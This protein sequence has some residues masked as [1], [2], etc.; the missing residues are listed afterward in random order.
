[1]NIVNDNVQKMMNLK[2]AVAKAAKNEYKW[3]FHNPL[4]ISGYNS[5]GFDMYFIVKQL[6]K[7]FDLSEYVINTVFKGSHM[8]Y[9][10]IFSTKAQ[11]V[12]LKSHDI[13][14]ITLCSLKKALESFCPNERRKLDFSD[15]I[16]YILNN[17]YKN[18]SIL[19][20]KDVEF[21]ML[22][23]N[24]KTNIHEMKKYKENLYKNL[25]TYAKN[26]T[27]VLPDLYQ[28]IN[29]QC[30]EILGIINGSIFGGRVY[31]RVKKIDNSTGKKYVMLDISGMYA[32]IMKTFSFPYGPSKFMDKEELNNIN[33]QVQKIMSYVEKDTRKIFAEL[34]YF[35]AQCDFEEN[36]NNLEPSIQ[37][38]CPTTKKTLWT[39]S[40][41]KQTI[42][43]IDLAIILKNGGKVYNISRVLKWDVSS[44]VFSKWIEYTLSIKNEGKRTHQPA[45]TAFGK[46]LANAAYGQTI[47]RDVIKMISNYNDT[48]QFLDSNKCNHVEH[49]NEKFQ[50]FYGKKTIDDNVF[51][52]SRS[53]YLGSFVLGFSRL[54]L[55]DIV[56]VIMPN[57]FDPIK[58]LEE[59]IIY[60]DTDSIIVQKWQADLLKNTPNLKIILS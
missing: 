25:I 19:D 29:E 1:M 59:M 36:E 27:N 16:M 39:N 8:V 56:S 18:K 14:Q 32:Y 24:E 51:K 50:V 44:Q 49:I 34:G 17:Y 46:I 38:K 33:K 7:K 2:T 22:K 6:Y 3:M 40:R 60:G 48:M 42:T 9:F 58:G 45:K 13:C 5:S 57:R 26:D 4:T 12:V 35:I 23:Y 55:D 10:T 30:L 41:R 53:L 52:T 11:C 37:Y 28:K 54:M 47:K 43:S 21:E 31:P 20:D 15:G